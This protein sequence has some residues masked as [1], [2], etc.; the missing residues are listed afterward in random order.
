[1]AVTTTTNIL[2]IPN[3]KH[4]IGKRYAKRFY[5]QAFSMISSG[6]VFNFTSDTSL[7]KETKFT[8]V[9]LGLR[10]EEKGVLKSGI[11]NDFGVG[12]RYNLLS[13]NTPKSFLHPNLLVEYRY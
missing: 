2:A 12:F 13:K 1:M 5:L 7:F 9:A 4:Y 6:K 11:F 8:E 3:I 10:I